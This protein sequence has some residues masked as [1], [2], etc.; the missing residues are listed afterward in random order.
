YD[1]K[2]RRTMNSVMRI[3]SG[4]AL[5]ALV[6]L[7][8]A[9]QDRGSVTAAA[10]PAVAVGPQRD[11]DPLRDFL[12]C[13][14][15]LDLSDE[16]NA[17]SDAVREAEKPTLEALRDTIQADRQTLHTDA[18]AVP[19]DP[20][21]V[22]ADFLKLREDRQAV[23]AEV[24][25]IKDFIVSQLTEAQKLRFDGCLRGSSAAGAGQ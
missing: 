6:S 19:A 20:C 2:R 25:K 14:R 23:A 3:G 15:V 9:G 8:A 22:G 21:K 16:Q 1:T 11:G 17:A 7:P 18:S 24:A 10:R 4:L 5:A 13:L 12:H